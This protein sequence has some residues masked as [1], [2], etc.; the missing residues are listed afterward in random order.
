MESMRTIWTQVQSPK[1]SFRRDEFSSQLKEIFIMDDSTSCSY[2]KRNVV[3]SAQ[4][5]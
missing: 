2:C 1:D 4:I 3:F 5:S